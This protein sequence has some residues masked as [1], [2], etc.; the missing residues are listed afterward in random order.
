MV[1]IVRQTR[2][3]ALQLDDVPPTLTCATCRATG[4]DKHAPIGVRVSLTGGA[5]DGAALDTGVCADCMAEALGILFG[6]RHVQTGGEISDLK[7][8]PT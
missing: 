7:G 4:V 2:G 3:G 1:S 6:R 5:G 8:D